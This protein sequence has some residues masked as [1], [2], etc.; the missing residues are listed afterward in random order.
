MQT[1]LTKATHALCHDLVDHTSHGLRFISNK[2]IPIGIRT[3]SQDFDSSNFICN[4]KG[5]SE[6]TPYGLLLDLL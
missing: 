2:E 3:T 5:C 1:P 6:M 4:L